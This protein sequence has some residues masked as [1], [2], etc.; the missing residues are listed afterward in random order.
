MM[1][2]N[3][4]IN[5]R[6]VHHAAMSFNCANA[7][8]SSS[9]VAFFHCWMVLPGKSSARRLASDHETRRLPLSNLLRYVWSMSR[10]FAM[11]FCFIMLDI[12]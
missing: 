9:G 8:R 2:A 4:R 1:M 5:D 7:C 6:W 12:L 10:R 11:S 3:D